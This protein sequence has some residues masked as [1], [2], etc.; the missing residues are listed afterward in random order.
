MSDKIQFKLRIANKSDSKNIFNLTNEEKV[1]ENV[2]NSIL[3]SWENYLK[4]FNEAL[5]SDNYLILVA[6]DTSNQF[7]GQVYYKIENNITF[8]NIS[9]GE[10][11]RGMDLAAPIIN[12]STKF[13][14]SH[15]NN[16]ESIL[17]YIEDINIPSL[18]AFEQAGFLYYKD[19]IINNKKFHVYRYLR[20]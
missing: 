17:A 5:E 1:R 2:T 19:E 15:N 16:I 6:L 13:L 11:Y 14:F 20:N 7:I 12:E 8:I 4:W 18:R 9:I 3:V 10:E